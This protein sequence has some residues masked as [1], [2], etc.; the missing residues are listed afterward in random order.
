MFHKKCLTFQSFIHK[1][2]CWNLYIFNWYND[3]KHISR[4]FTQKT[5]RINA[6]RCLD[7]LA[8]IRAYSS[9]R[10]TLILK[11]Y[12]WISPCLCRMKVS[13]VHWYSGT[14]ILKGIWTF[15]PH[16]NI[17]KKILYTYVFF[18]HRNN[19]SHHQR[20]TGFHTRVRG[21]IELFIT[22][23]PK[24]FLLTIELWRIVLN[25]KWLVH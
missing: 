1:K 22:L 15:H 2:P 3:V 20:I 23:V 11:N 9:L 25:F 4:I 14:V 7:S 6:G 19:F 5:F 8:L 24:A 18:R 16:G 10:W 17:Y 12:S 21:D 13:C